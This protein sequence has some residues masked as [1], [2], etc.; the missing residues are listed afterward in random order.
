MRTIRELDWR[1][2]VPEPE[3]AAFVMCSDFPDVPGLWDLSLRPEVIPHWM[4]ILRANMRYLQQIVETQGHQEQVEAAQDIAMIL[5]GLFRD[6]EGG[7]AAAEVRTIHEVTLIR[8]NLLRSNGLIDPYWEIKA[9]EAERLM[10][11]ARGALRE[12]WESGG[13]ESGKPALAGL[14]AGMLGGN[15]FD[16]GSRSTQEAFCK[17]QLDTEAACARFRPW[18]AQTL[19]DMEPE[20]ADLLFPRPRQLG[21]PPEGRVI[22]FADNAGADFLLGVLPMALFLARRWE[23]WIAVNSLPSSSDIAIEEACALLAGLRSGAED[24]VALAMH[25]GR[26][27]LVAS[28]TGSPGIDLRYVGAELN[29]VAHDAS[30]ILLE[31]QGR[32]IETNWTTRFRC[33]VF[34]LAVVKDALV[35]QELGL[36]P[37]SPVLRCDRG[38]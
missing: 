20:A 9:R 30:W 21:E 18:V 3:G 1:Q 8:D 4:A 13:G 28:G 36:E 15:L 17:G 26:L 23:V 33:T 35:A 14:L 37:N 11:Q 6:L 29:R 31:G 22:L 25:S 19:R 12:A 34:R 24:P 5:D 10:P 38:A 32:G 16:L 27:R 7:G 2:W